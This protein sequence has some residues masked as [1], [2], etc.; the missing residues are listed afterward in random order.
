MF[1]EKGSRESFRG[2]GK[3]SRRIGMGE[4]R[5]SKGHRW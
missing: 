2:K 1:R 5:A 4:L 3:F